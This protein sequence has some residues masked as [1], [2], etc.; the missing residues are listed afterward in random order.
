MAQ[1]EA[2]ILAS[3]DAAQTNAVILSCF[4][5][6]YFNAQQQGRQKL[7]LGMQEQLRNEVE[8]STGQPFGMFNALTMRYKRII[9]KG[10]VERKSGSGRKSKF[11]DEI[12]ERTKKILRHSHFEIS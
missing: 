11:T 8:R 4:R 6:A 12:V 5:S 10:T 9:G 1:Q 2:V 3:M 7:T